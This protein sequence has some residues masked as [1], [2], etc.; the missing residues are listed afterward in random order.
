MAT[1]KYSSYISKKRLDIV[2]SVMY[3]II[4]VIIC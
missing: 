4:E 1:E 2:I 3:N